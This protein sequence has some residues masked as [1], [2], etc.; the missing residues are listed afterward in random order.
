MMDIEA[1]ARRRGGLNRDSRQPEWERRLIGA[2]ASSARPLQH[3]AKAADDPA[4]AVRVFRSD[5]KLVPTW[6]WF[7]I[8]PA[9]GDPIG[10]KDI[11]GHA[12]TDSEL[13]AL[14]R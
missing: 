9:V 3:R 11:T 10:R 14:V 13:E 5:E 12:H 7:A 8:I 4:E 6:I 1:E 2:V